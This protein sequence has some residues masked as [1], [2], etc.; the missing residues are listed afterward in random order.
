MTLNRKPKPSIPSILLYDNTGLQSFTNAGEFHTWDT[1]QIKTSHFWYKI[2]GTKVILENNQ[3]NMYEVTFE[4]SFYT[5]SNASITLQSD[6]YKNGVIV[7]GSQSKMSLVG[8]GQAA[9]VRNCLSIHFLLYLKGGD[10]IQIKSI[11]N[12]VN[13]V[14]STADTSRLMINFM[15]IRGWDNSKAGRIE[16]KGSV[17]R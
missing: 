2:D 10:Y 11:T 15:P 9:T 3:Q 5:Y 13:A 8:S 14:L 12:N 7:D 17:L 16:Y 4:C 6:I 1:E